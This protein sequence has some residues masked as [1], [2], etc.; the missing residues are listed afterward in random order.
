MKEWPDQVLAAISVKSDLKIITHPGNPSRLV[1]G[2]VLERS[3][4]YMFDAR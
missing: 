3:S 1:K 2:P 4:Y